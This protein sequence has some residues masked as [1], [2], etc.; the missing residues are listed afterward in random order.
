MLPAIADYFGTSI[1]NLLGTDSIQKETD[2]ENYRR[3]YSDLIFSPDKQLDLAEKYH[4]K[5]PGSIDIMQNLV[6]LLAN[7]DGKTKEV[8]KRIETLCNRILSDTSDSKQKQE[9]LFT[10]CMMAE[11][12]NA[13]KYL[14]QC[15]SVTTTFF[16]KSQ[17]EKMHFYAITQ[18]PPKPNFRYTVIFSLEMNRDCI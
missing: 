8:C 12:P 13:N 9:A 18:A 3:Q 15:P 4:K 14:L 11:E 10:L 1:D 16:R 5:Y 6:Y 17:Q 7:Q 2:L